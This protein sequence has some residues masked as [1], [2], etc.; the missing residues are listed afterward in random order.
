MKKEKLF[1][2]HLSNKLCKIN[3]SRQFVSGD[4]DVVQP[5]AI[6]DSTS[7]RALSGILVGSTTLQLALATPFCMA[8]VVEI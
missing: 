1:I 2:V 6:S 7:G 3:A 4:L 5:P 8:V